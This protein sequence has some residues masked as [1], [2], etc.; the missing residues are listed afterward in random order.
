MPAPGSVTPYYLVTDTFPAPAMFFVSVPGPQAMV[1][2]VPGRV[3]DTRSN[4]HSLWSGETMTLPVAGSR[5]VPVSG[6]A[7]VVLNVTVTA[8]TG[9]GYLTVWPTGTTRPVVSSLNW[10]AGKTIANQVVVK[11]GTNGS[12]DLFQSGPGVADVIVDVAGYFID[13]PGTEPGGFVPLSP[14]RI[15]DTRTTG[16]A[17]AAGQSRDLQVTGAG[18][19]PGSNV[20]A[21]VLNVTVTDTTAGGFLTVYPSG[22]TKP[23]ASNLNWAAGTTV[24]NLVTVKLGSNGKVSLFQSGPGTAQVIVDVAGY[25]VGGTPTKVGMFV[26]LDPSRVLDTRTT[27]KVAARAN[28]G[29]SILGK[30]GI[31]TSR[32]AAVVLNATATDTTAAGYLTVFPSAYVMPYASTLNW[33]AGA[34]V[35]NLV[36]VKLNTYGTLSFYNGSAG[37]SQFIADTAGYYLG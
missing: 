2:L 20:S 5:G 8:P 19:V 6:A 22:T 27:G 28:A 9:N 14:S 36:T 24:P 12:I 3:V 21:V 4:G 37:P 16:G 29:L 31:P 23:L 30:G 7:A 18:G 1:P 17:V 33:N 13:G 11:L 25:Y 34:T 15:L 10:S 32:V 35:P 26:A